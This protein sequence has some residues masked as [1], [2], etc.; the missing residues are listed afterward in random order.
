MRVLIADDSSMSRDWLVDM[1]AIHEQMEIVKIC[2]NG[3]SALEA[4]QVLKPDLAI[5]DF[6]MPGLNGLEVLKEIRK[7]DNKLQFIM[8]TFYAFDNYRQ[9]AMQAGADYF[10]SKADDYE[11]LKTLLRKLVKE[12][13]TKLNSNPNTLQQ[14]NHNLPQQDINDK[15]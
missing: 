11:N 3:T 9:A 10:F 8:L 12:E 14:K 1:F 4:L 7:T 6:K 13:E 2:T 15:Q 5:I